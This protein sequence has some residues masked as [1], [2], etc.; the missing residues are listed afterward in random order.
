MFQNYVYNFAFS[1]GNSQDD[2]AYVDI[3]LSKLL[4]NI[5]SLTDE[6]TKEVWVG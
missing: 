2:S 6:L 5:G 4:T 3:E 1:E